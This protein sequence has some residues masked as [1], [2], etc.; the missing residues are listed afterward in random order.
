MESAMANE[1]KKHRDSY[2]LLANLHPF[3]AYVLY[4]H[5]NERTVQ[6]TVWMLVN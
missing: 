5:L 4:D 6:K 2:I 3:H 1:T